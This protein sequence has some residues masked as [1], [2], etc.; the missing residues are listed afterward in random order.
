[1][2]LDLYKRAN[3]A[4]NIRFMLNDLVLYFILNWRYLFCTPN[5]CDMKYNNA[6][7]KRTL[8]FDGNIGN[9]NR[10]S[11]K[12]RKQHSLLL[13]IYIIIYII[14]IYIY[15]IFFYYTSFNIIKIYK[16]L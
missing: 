12:Q 7:P 6:I 5:T 2:Y 8:R 11:S 9:R 15:Y 14:I 4:Y 3:S 10:N 13:Y 16:Y 1:M